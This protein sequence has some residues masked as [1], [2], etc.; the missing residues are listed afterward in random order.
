VQSDADTS[1]QVGVAASGETYAFEVV[2]IQPGDSNGIRPYAPAISIGGQYFI[3]PFQA[4]PMAGFVGDL[5]VVFSAEPGEVRYIGAPSNADSRWLAK[6]QDYRFTID[7]VRDE[8]L[9][10][11]QNSIAT[12]LAP[13]CIV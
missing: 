4:M 6:E 9:G 5:N 2:P 10:R 8:G 3:R 11:M 13:F 12:W 1:L 7:N